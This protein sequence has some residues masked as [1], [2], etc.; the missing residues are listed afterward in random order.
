MGVDSTADVPRGQWVRALLL[1]LIALSTY[2]SVPLVSG[3]RML[4]PSFPTVALLPILF[5]VVWRDVDLSDCVFMLKVF[6]VLIASIALSPGLAYATQKI[7][8]LIQCCMGIVAAAVA[9]K[10]MQQMRIVVLERALCALW[11]L[12]IAGCLL[13]IAGI[14]TAASDSFRTWAYG[15]TFTVYDAINRDINM[16]GWLRPKLF[17]VEPSHVT[18]LFIASVNAWLIVRVT[19]PKVWITVAATLVML[20]IMGS[21]MILASAAIT[22][23]VVLWN[24]R[25]KPRTKVAMVL[26]AVIVASVFAAFYADSR[27]AVISDR[28]TNINEESIEEGNEMGSEEK[29]LVYPYVVLVETL[30]LLPFFC[31]GFGLMV[32]LF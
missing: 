32:V 7:F 27:V 17:S 13:E 14:I 9:V 6:F 18:K 25:A 2:L 15:D 3:G 21:P 8:A 11:V 23:A 16:V 4:V 1:I 20:I 22:F 19:W 30:L 29:R 31:L 26:V 12:V 28:L 24:T 5:V 10:L